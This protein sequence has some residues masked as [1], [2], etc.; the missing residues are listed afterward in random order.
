MVCK[1]Y[2]GPSY[3]IKQLFAIKKIR[4]IFSTLFLPNVERIITR[5]QSHGAAIISGSFF[6]LGI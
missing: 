2:K 4:D 3:D 1:L 6:P 5:L